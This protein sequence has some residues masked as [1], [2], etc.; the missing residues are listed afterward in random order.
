MIGTVMRHTRGSTRRNALRSNLEPG[1]RRCGAVDR[2]AGGVATC[3]PQPQPQ[4]LHH[5]TILTF[6]RPRTLASSSDRPQN[7]HEYQARL[8]RRIPSE[9]GHSG[10][11]ISFNHTK[12]SLA[13]L[14][15]PKAHGQFSLKQM[16]PPMGLSAPKS[17]LPRRTT[18]DVACRVARP[19]S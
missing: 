15:T 14:K 3:T 10:A 18:P 17:P 11:L 6:Q 16:T 5:T 7:W 8:V 4:P 19:R 2:Q 9:S 12:I 13:H 1:A